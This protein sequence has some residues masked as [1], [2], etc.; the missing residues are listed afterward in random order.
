M[1][2]VYDCS[3]ALIT[4]SLIFICTYFVV[5]F[6]KHLI[7][8]TKSLSTSNGSDPLPLT[9]SVIQQ[10]ISETF[11]RQYIKIVVAAPPF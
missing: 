11:N 2:E 8:K 1:I 4:T 5:K 7:S 6:A 10:H 9:T 3:F